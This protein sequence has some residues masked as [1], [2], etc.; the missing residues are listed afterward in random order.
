MKSKISTTKGCIKLLFVVG[1]VSAF[2]LSPTLAQPPANVVVTPVVQQDVAPTGSFVATITPLKRTTIGSAVDGRVAERNVEIGDRVVAKKPLFQ[3]LTNTIN[4]ELKAAEAELAVRQEQLTELVN[5]PRPAEIEQAKAKMSAAEASAKYAKSQRDRMEKL[6]ATK[7]VP[8]DDFDAAIAA[9][10][11]AQQN[12]LDLKAAYDLAVEGTR[13]E[14]ID[15]AKAFV[16]LQIAEI[17]R[18]KD[19]IA[20]YTIISRFD[21]YVVN[22]H[23]EV[24]A[25]VQTGDPIVDVVELDMIELE[26]HVAEQHVNHI[27]KGV[28]VSVSVPSIRKKP[29]KGTVQ[30]VNPQADVRART[31]PVIVRVENEITDDGPLLKAGMAARIDLPTG[32]VQKDALLVP[33]DALVLGGQSPTVFVVVPG[34][35]DG[36]KAVPVPVKTGFSSAS[37]IQ[38]TGDIKP[39]QQVVVEGNERLRPGQAVIIAGEK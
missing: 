31:F 23:V 29:F 14:Q 19:R 9:Y 20:K 39:G 30:T 8:K 25:W 36:K 38:I 15:R 35:K 5:G 1:I 27:K 13:K 33:K 22:W 10:D 4:L 17:A 37:L 24:G 32:P 11:A 6:Y 2:G 18:I 28:Q 7:T 21:G 26:A 34:D 16:N 3:L 12:Y